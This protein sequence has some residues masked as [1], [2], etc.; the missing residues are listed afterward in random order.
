MRNAGCGMTNDERRVPGA[1]RE[2]PNEESDS[3]GV[4]PDPRLPTPDSQ[5]PPPSVTGLIYAH[6]DEAT[7]RSAIDD[8]SE[9][10]ADG[11]SEFEIL[12]VDDASTDGTAAAADEAA[13]GRPAVRLIRREGPSGYGAALRDAVAEARFP[14]IVQTDARS[15]LDL[16]ALDAFLELRTECDIVIGRRRAPRGVLKRPFGGWRYWLLC[17]VVFGIPLR[18]I[19]CALRLYRREVFDRIHIQ[20]DGPFADA[21]VLAKAGFFGMMIGEVPVEQRAPDGP[22]TPRVSLFTCRML[23][24]AWRVLRHPVLLPPEGTDAE[25]AGIRG[26][27]SGVRDGKP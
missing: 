6:N 24:E 8:L 27:G 19:N 10:L 21:E 2:V 7:V 4:V 26:Q 12:V 20:S 5:L 14:L 17:R 11:A 22:S 16:S 1:E 13:G 15:C 3:P 9:A 25:R 23:R 18:D